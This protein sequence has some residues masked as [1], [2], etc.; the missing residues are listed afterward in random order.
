M[1]YVYP[2]SFNS[3]VPQATGQVISFMRNPARYKLMQ[4]VQLVKSEKSVGV[5]YKINPD[6]SARLPNTDETVWHHGAKRPTHQHEG[7][8]HDLVE[9][10]TTRHDFGFTLDWEVVKQADY[11][12]LVGY[13]NL[14][15]NQAMIHRTQRFITLMETA[16]NWGNMTDT[17]S[18]L[19][20]GAG[21]WDQATS[22][23][24]SPFYLAIKKTLDQVAE[25]I[26]LATNG[27]VGEFDE[28]TGQQAGLKLLIAPHLAHK[29]GQSDEMHNYIRESPFA[30]DEIKGKVPGVNAKWG[31]PS[32]IYGWD[33]I[34]EN[35]VRDRV[36]PNAGTTADTTT[37]SNPNKNFIKSSS[38]A[39]VC[40]RAG[41][42][43]GQYGAPSFSTFQLYYH[44]KETEVETF[45]H[46]E[47]RLTT[48]HVTIDDKE[49]LA[50]APAGFLIQNCLSPG[51]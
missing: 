19:N 10:Q 34:V 46:P 4:Y 47:D 27:S 5:Y 14:P 51:A 22:D 29:M 3:F 7:V 31:L 12:I 21:Y 28:E 26:H 16:S 33:L 49:V 44:G 50:A 30:R 43:D 32:S 38:S 17:A 41:G 24:T 9:F 37:G 13:T 42:I 18:N 35:A 1:A 25:L 36:R 40:S 11:P 39:V 20:G 2:G 23:R 45:D 6:D 8:R 48:G 15:R